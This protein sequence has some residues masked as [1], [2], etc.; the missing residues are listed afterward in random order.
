[1]HAPSSPHAPDVHS[2]SEPHARHTLASQIGVVPE[3]SLFITHWTHV[4]FEQIV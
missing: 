4:P 1:M 3:Q 2:E